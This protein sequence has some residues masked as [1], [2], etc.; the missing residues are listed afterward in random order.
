MDHEIEQLEQRVDRVVG[1]LRLLA[2]ER[3]RL[4]Q[5]VRSLEARLRRAESGAT[6]REPVPRRGDADTRMVVDALREALNALR[7]A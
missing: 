7:G 2:E 3:T 1:R 6:D 4:L 5:D